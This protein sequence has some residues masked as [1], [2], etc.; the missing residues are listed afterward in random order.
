M[1]RA[2]RLR[3]PLAVGSAWCGTGCALRAGA[4]GARGTMGATLGQS[5][6]KKRKTA[7]SSSQGE[8]RLSRCLRVSPGR[9]EKEEAKESTMVGAM[10][11]AS[12]DTGGQGAPCT[13][14]RAPGVSQIAALYGFWCD[15]CPVEDPVAKT[16]LQQAA[17]PPGPSGSR[18]TNRLTPDI[19]GT[20]VLGRSL[21]LPSW[22]C[23]PSPWGFRFPRLGSEPHV[24]QG[25][26]WC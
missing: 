24:A 20:S 19:V 21:Q 4:R 25:G 23:V 8:G 15:K 7:G 3:R 1:G 11:L 16:A 22:S 17:R 18:G 14:L 2:L 6:G 9:R 26:Y 13:G 10:G 12:V 5:G